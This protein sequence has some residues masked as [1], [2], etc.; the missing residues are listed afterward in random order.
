MVCLGLLCLFNNLAQAQSGVYLNST[1]QLHNSIIWGNVDAGFEGSQL[2]GTG[3]VAYTAVQGATAPAGSNNQAL[4]A[5]PFVG[6]GTMQEPLSVQQGTTLNAGNNPLAGSENLTDAAGYARVWNNTVD[7]G[8]YEYQ[9][10]RTLTITTQSASKYFGQV[11]P[12]FSYAVTGDA[13]LPT[14]SV[15][16]QLG[17]V[18]GETAGN[19]NIDT[20]SVRVYR[21][22]SAIPN[23]YTVNVI[24]G[25]LTVVPLRNIT[26]TA[27]AVEKFVGEG[28]PTLTYILSGDA[29]GA[30]DSV[31]VQLK[32]ATGET[33]GTYDIDTTSVRIFKKVG[34]TDVR[35]QYNVTFVK[36]QLTVQ[37]LRNITITAQAAEKFVGEGDPTFTYVLSGDAIVAGDSVSV[38]LTRTTG[39]T[40]GIY[41][42]DTASVR[43]FKKVGNQNVRSH[44]TVTAVKGQ[45]TIQALRNITIT[46]QAA[47]KFVGES[48]PTFTYVL[49]GDALVAGDNI[50][51]QL[52]RAVGETAGTYSIDTASVRIFKAVGGQ[53]VRNHYTITVVKSQLTVHALRNITITIADAE[54]TEGEDDPEFTYVLSGDNAVAGDSI[55]VQLARTEGQTFGTYEIDTASVR[56]FKKVGG[57]STKRHYAITVVKGNFTIVKAPI[58]TVAKNTL[59]V[60]VYP[61]MTT[62]TLYISGIEEIGQLKVEVYNAGGILLMNKVYGAGT[63]VVDLSAMPKGTLFVKLTSGG[64]SVTKQIVKQ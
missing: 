29:V 53:N 51:I 15:S 22:G 30:G 40:A 4:V 2:D 52:K 55:V 59:Q 10:P 3:E 56:I 16:I 20:A 47:E 5:T 26:I 27:Q 64:K 44:Y 8:A 60:N 33:A 58:T 21:L 19:Y 39:E 36:S 57:Q 7:M 49:S 13:L 28:D 6:D 18:T 54:K 23:Q 43:I 37:A 45:L 9:F 62:G 24:K 41:N 32:R 1:S 14:D 17:R 48:D 63:S 46:T 61:T 25:Q 31:S 12:Q 35:Y 38:Q 11:D 42:I 34:N 50:N